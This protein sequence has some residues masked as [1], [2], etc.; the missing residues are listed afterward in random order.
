[1][2][3]RT[4]MILASWAGMAWGA[5]PARLACDGRVWDFGTVANH[6]DV[7]H[8]F[9]LRN[10]GGT[11]LSIQR[12]RACCG[13]TA[14]LS[15][16]IIPPGEAVELTVR[17]SL[18]GRLGAQKKSVYVISDD[19]VESCFPIQLSGTATAALV[20]FPPRLDFGPVAAAGG[21][22]LMA[23]ILSVTGG[24]FHVTNLSATASWAVPRWEPESN[25]TSGK[26]WVNI[27]P[28]LP[29]GALAGRVILLTDLPGYPRLDLPV[30]ARLDSEVVVVPQALV[31][32]GGAAGGATRYVAIQR[33]GGKPFQ[34]LGVETP[35]KEITADVAPLGS[36]GY[37]VAISGIGAAAGLK[38]KVL[39]L[40]TDVK[41]MEEI[42]VP[43]IPE[44]E[45]E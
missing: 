3:T 28:P 12:V 11:P 26:L 37:R 40:R 30:L 42:E 15:S 4:M 33:R 17:L 7:E 5:G 36:N 2:M 6:Q 24:V 21:G 44:N 35:E 13:A 23:R 31:L 16:K 27:Q 25:G 10:E 43:F 45:S 20:A 34:L 14:A 29:E 32:R 19:P 18:A 9:Q 39:T 1:M 38:G 22:E 8:V 41:G